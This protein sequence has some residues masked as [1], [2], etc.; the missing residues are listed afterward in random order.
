MSHGA[1]TQY[2][3]VF[4][5]IVSGEGQSDNC[6]CKVLVGLRYFMKIESM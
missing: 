1:K 2:P 6:D 4:R 5:R 3:W